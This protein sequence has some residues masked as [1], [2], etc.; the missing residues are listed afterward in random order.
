ME[1]DYNDGDIVFVQQVEQIE[2]G[3]IGVFFVNG[4]GYIKEYGG[5]SLISHN[6]KYGNKKAWKR[7]WVCVSRV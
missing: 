5:D 2:L 3:Q 6:P 4:S 1:P 7:P